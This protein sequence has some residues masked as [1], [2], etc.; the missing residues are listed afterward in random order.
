M[1]FFLL[2]LA[3]IGIAALLVGGGAAMIVISW[4]KV[5]SF[6]GQL[7]IVVACIG[8]SLF[9]MAAAGLVLFTIAF[10]MSDM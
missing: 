2:I 9:A 8:G 4:S 10:G 1:N 7:G 5:N 3:V 6:A